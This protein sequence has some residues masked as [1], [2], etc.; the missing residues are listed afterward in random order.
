MKRQTFTM[1]VAVALVLAL[2]GSAPVF[3]QAGGGNPGTAAGGG[4]GT[5]TGP[6]NPAG[7]DA[8]VEIDLPI[9]SSRNVIE[10]PPQEN[11][12]DETDD[13]QLYN[14]DLP[15]EEDSIIYVLDI[16]GSMDWGTSTYTGLDGNPTSG[17]RLDRAKV[18]LI[19]SINALSENFMF[20]VLAYDCDIYRWS[21]ARQQATPA[22]KA[23]A[24]GWVSSRRAMGATGTGPAVAAAL[25]DRANFTI[26][27]LSD[28]APNCL[29]DN[30]SAS[31]DD[32]KR[33][34]RSANQQNATIHCFGIGAYGEFK[35]FLQDV[36][37]ENGNGR[38]YDVP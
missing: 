14:E 4:G 9:G 24:V 21:G 33:T 27:L 32:H 29:G 6:S 1:A 10:E 11:P 18:E 5:G 34:I 12:Y 25:A 26:A 17:S 38:Y 20:N 2:A 13:P 28:G 8:S 7:A 37:R 15:V 3:A 19:R 23:S 36:A 35:Q 22:A 30:W 16:S 31:I